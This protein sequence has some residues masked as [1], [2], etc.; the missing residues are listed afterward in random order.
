MSFITPIC[1][2]ATV[3]AE[4]V[5]HA[6]AL[7]SFKLQRIGV[8]YTLHMQTQTQ[9][10]THV[11][12]SCTV[13]C[14]DRWLAAKNAVSLAHLPPRPSSTWFTT[15]VHN[16]QPQRARCAGHH[17]SHCSPDSR[18]MQALAA[19]AAQ[20]RVGVTSVQIAGRYAGKRDKHLTLR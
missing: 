7:Y 1:Y 19:L 3:Q 11:T 5:P 17:Q 6:A 18:K 4:L 15:F 2:T 14:V 10:I 9:T 16:C 12:P 20:L 13:M 8:Y